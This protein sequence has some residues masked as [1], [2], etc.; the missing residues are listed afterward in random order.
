MVGNTYHDVAAGK[1][2]GCRTILIKQYLKLPVKKQGDPDA[3]FEAV[4]LREAV[5]IIKRQTMPKPVVVAAS[6]PVAAVVPVQAAASVVSAPVV[7]PPSPPAAPPVVAPASVVNPVAVPPVPPTVIPVEVVPESVKPVIEPEPIKI[8]SPVVIGKPA[9]EEIVPQPLE[10][11]EEEQIEEPKA[12]ETV[13]EKPQQKTVEDV[14][15]KVPAG[16]SSKTEKLL[17][18]IRLMMKSRN[19]QELYTEFS[20]LKLFAGF[21][22]IVVLGCL[23]I[24]LRY[25]MSPIEADSA[26]YTAIGF[27]IVFQIMTLTLYIMHRDK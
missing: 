22:Q 10:E 2:A 13:E 7:V 4:N 19:R 25:K 15:F 18:E 12:A 16:D 27:A 5:N 6:V 23:F 20:I 21:M 3:D 26:V 11:E 1:A 8:K 17:E 9:E 14:E 24:A